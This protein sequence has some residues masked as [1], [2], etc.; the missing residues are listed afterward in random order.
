MHMQ[1]QYRS[2]QP[3]VVEKPIVQP[4]EKKPQKMDKRTLY[5]ALGGVFLILVCA[6]VGTGYLLASPK[7][8]ITI[9]GQTVST[10]GG[11]TFGSSDTKTFTDTAVGTI[12]KDGIDGEGTHKLIRE[13]GPSQTAC[14]VSSVLDLDEFAGKKVK[15]ASKT[16]AAKKC[17]WLMDVGRIELQ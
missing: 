8:T 10:G 14:L 7:G 9:A 13:G 17:P 1:T 4:L 15:V 5:I 3:E 16:M 11:K 2:H 12:E 6:G